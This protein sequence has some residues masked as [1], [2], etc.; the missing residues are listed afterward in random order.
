M[1]LDDL[2]LPRAAVNVG[3]AGDA[4]RG[5]GVVAWAF[6]EGRNAAMKCAEYLRR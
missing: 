6:T 2:G 5:S 4:R 3:A 1:M